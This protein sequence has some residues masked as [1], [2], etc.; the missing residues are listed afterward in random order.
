MVEIRYVRKRLFVSF[1][2][3]RKKKCIKVSI[4]RIFDRNS[5]G[6]FNK[7]LLINRYSYKIHSIE[8]DYST[9]KN[10]YTKENS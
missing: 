10:L 2:F 7:S 5:I 3:S 9:G 4:I 6:A 8:I 1:S